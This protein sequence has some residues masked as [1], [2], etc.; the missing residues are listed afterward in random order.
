MTEEGMSKTLDA[1][2]EEAE[3]L[4]TLDV[5][6]DVRIGLQL[7]ISIARHKFDVRSAEEIKQ[8]QA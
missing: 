6:P 2:S 8:H 4:L 1:I 7:I 5:S 3:K